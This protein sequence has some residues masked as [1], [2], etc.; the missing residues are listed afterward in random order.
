MK[1]K[2]LACL[3]VVFAIGASVSLAQSAVS[4]NTVE[5]NQAKKEYKKD[6]KKE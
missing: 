1:R 5:G 2:I 6:G 3:A 4:A